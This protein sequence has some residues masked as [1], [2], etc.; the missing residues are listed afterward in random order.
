[1][2]TTGFILT[3]SC[4]DQPG[5]VHAVSGLLFQ[6]G[7]NIVDSDQYGDAFTG[8]FFMRVHFSTA[9]GGPSLAELRAAFAPVGEQF[10]MQWE[11]FD[12]TVKPRVMIMVSKIGHCLNDLLFRAK[13]GG[14]P[15]EIAA[16]VS[17]HRD[18]YQLAASYDVP[19][20]HLPLMNASAE[21]KA[22]QE[23]RVFEVVRDQNIEI[24]RAHV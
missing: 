1:M 18:F 2:S 15:V 23:A 22:A 20:F 13:A 19:F 5:I 12:A 6:H 8:R 16:I 14:L 9:A 7:C 21:Q 4:P 24:G 10:G 3:I 17:N 11:V